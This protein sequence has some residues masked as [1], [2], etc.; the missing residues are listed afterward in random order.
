[1][2]TSFVYVAPFGYIETKF[3]FSRLLELARLSAIELEEEENIERAGG[4]P[5]VQRGHFV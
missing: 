1:M 3:A 2:T 5:A 4:M